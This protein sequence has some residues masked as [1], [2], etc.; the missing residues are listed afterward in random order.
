MPFGIVQVPLSFL[1]AERPV[2]THEKDMELY[3]VFPVERDAGTELLD[4]WDDVLF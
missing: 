2:R 3:A 4:I 1:A